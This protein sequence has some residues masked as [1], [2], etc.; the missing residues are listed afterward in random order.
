[1]WGA[2]SNYLKTAQYCIASAEKD[3]EA[4]KGC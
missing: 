2:G 3:A 1:M 4:Q